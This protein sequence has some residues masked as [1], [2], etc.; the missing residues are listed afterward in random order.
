MVLHSTHIPPKRGQGLRSLLDT[1][2]KKNERKKQKHYATC[3]Q[4]YLKIITAKL[5]KNKT[6]ETAKK[7]KLFM[8]HN[9]SSSKSCILDI[10]ENNSYGVSSNIYTT[11]KTD[12]TIAKLQNFLAK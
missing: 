5:G 6:L 8:L 9:V 11:S 4:T 3:Q 12:K 1:K 2:E 10:Q 7:E